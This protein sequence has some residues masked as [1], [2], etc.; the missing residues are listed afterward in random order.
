MATITGYQGKRIDNTSVRDEP[1]EFTL[2]SGEAIT[3]FDEAVEGMRVGGARRARVFC[4]LLWGGG[5]S[6]RSFA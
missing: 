2:G 6:R 1:Y 5:E 4:C 3:A